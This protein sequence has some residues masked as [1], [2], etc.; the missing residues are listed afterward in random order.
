MLGNSSVISKQ[1]IHTTNFLLRN[2][3]YYLLA[4]TNTLDNGEIKK[5]IKRGLKMRF[6][7]FSTLNDMF[8]HFEQLGYLDFYTLPVILPHGKITR[9]F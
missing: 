6:L 1:V 9:K 2:V 3:S 4:R 8:T 5:S 7:A